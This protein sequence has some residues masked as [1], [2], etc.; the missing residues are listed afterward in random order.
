MVSYGTKVSS[1]SLSAR[2]A[3]HPGDQASRIPMSAANTAASRPHV[4]AVEVYRRRAMV[5]GSKPAMAN[6][7]AEAM[8][9]PGSAWRGHV[10]EHSAQ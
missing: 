4:N 8:N 2:P 1:A 3:G 7:R 10:S 6:R 9:S 5:V